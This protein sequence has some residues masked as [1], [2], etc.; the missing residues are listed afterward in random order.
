MVAI[1]KRVERNMLVNGLLALIPDAI[2][3]WIVATYAASGVVGFILTLLALQPGAAQ[4]CRVGIERARH[5]P[6]HAL[7]LKNLITGLVR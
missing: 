5:S 6:S 3:A 4:R 7:H 1:G 2:I